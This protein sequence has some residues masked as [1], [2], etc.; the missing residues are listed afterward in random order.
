M[1]QNNQIYRPL[2]D[3]ISRLQKTNEALTQENTNLKISSNLH[4]EK[5][6]EYL[7]KLEANDQELI[8]TLTENKKLSRK[9]Q[10][11][12]QENLM[13][14]K[15]LKEAEALNK[16]FLIQQKEKDSIITRFQ[17]ELQIIG[18][19][20]EG[21]QSKH[22]SL[23]SQLE[24]TEKK[25]LEEKEKANFF[26]EL[27]CGL[28]QF[29]EV[30]LKN[31]LEFIMNMDSELRILQKNSQKALEFIVNGQAFFGSGNKN[32]LNFKAVESLKQI[33]EFGSEILRESLEES[34]VLRK[35]EM[36][37]KAKDDHKIENL[38]RTLKELKT[39]DM[40]REGEEKEW[41]R[42]LERLKEMNSILTR[43]KEK[44]NNE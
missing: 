22:F 17:E 12:Q 21:L 28:Q 10:D 11:L 7:G 43:E 33:F 40:F 30:S 42:E 25:F 4:Q 35:N 23:L 1:A 16:E 3:Q 44:E 32:N 37:I 5:L 29:L 19:Q 8:I 6:R 27:S 13:L 20:S 31:N 26:M 24:E 36:E 18:N 34:L 14:T 41:R 2:K 39:E 38:Q 15:Q 9:M